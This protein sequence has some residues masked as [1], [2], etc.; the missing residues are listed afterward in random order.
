MLQLL[1]RSGA[2][3]AS[4]L[5]I[6]WFLAG[7]GVGVPATVGTVTTG[8]SKLLSL[9]TTLGGVLGGVAADRLS[10]TVLESLTGNDGGG[11]G[12]GGGEFTCYD[13]LTKGLGPAC[14]LLVVLSRSIRSE[15]SVA[16][17]PA[18]AVALAALLLE[19]LF[20]AYV[21]GG[22]GSSSSSSTVAPAAAAAA[23]RSGLAR[24]LLLRDVPQ[25]VL[26][27]V[28]GGGGRKRSAAAAATAASASASAAAAAAALVARARWLTA[29]AQL[30]L[31]AAVVLAYAN[32]SLRLSRGPP[33]KTVGGYMSALRSL[34]AKKRGTG[35]WVRIDQWGTGGGG[36]DGSGGGGGGGRA[37]SLFGSLYETLMMGTGWGGGGRICPEAMALAQHQKRYD[38]PPFER[39]EVTVRSIYCSGLDAAITG[40]PPSNGHSGGGGGANGGVAG[41]GL[42]GGADGGGG[43]LIAGGSSRPFYVTVSLGGL[44]AKTSARQGFSPRFTEV[45]PLGCDC[46]I[47]GAYLT[48]AV[49]DSFETGRSGRGDRVVGEVHLPLEAAQLVPGTSGGL[50]DNGA[51]MFSST[52]SPS[53]G[54]DGDNGPA[55]RLRGDWELQGALGGPLGGARVGADIMVHGPPSPSSAAGRL[56]RRRRESVGWYAR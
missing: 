21:L 48:I 32:V 41:G 1:L 5:N 22:A 55:Y 28:G 14:L 45:F 25:R 20:S 30:V 53:G 46:P 24:L 2:M 16:V 56:R 11:G 39:G 49:V 13:V 19:P 42:A 9:A 12:G 15:P 4:S 34:A 31:W 26:G 52:S 36:C 35:G 44:T 29:G 23:T 38:G 7:A 18:A 50:D 43:G 33:G 47:R 6:P 37:N 51:D 54:W 27:Q 40:R 10:T 8:N 3:W 17:K